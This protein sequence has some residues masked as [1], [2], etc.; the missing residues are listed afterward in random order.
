MGGDGTREIKDF[1][2]KVKT[3]FHLDLIILFGSRG[4]GRL[5][6]R[7]WLWSHHC[8]SQIPKCAFPGAHIPTFRILGL[9][10]GRGPPTLHPRRV[11]EEEKPDRNSKPGCKGRFSIGGL[12]E[13]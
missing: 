8:K 10:P 12:K 1:L 7:Q 6:K 2:D 9:W 3:E 13:R 11:P 5:S 4:P